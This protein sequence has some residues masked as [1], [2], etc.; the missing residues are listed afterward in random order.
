MGRTD[1]GVAKRLRSL[2]ALQATAV[3]LAV[4]VGFAGAKAVD[5]GE[6]GD[7]AFI[8]GER[9]QQPVDDVMREEGA[10]RVVDQD[11]VGGKIC[12]R[13]E[14]AMHRF[15]PRRAAGN[16]QRAESLRGVRKG[17]GV[18]RV[19]HSHDLADARVTRERS[20]RTADH[21]LARQGPVLFR[22][23]FAR[24]GASPGG[25]DDRSDP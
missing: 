6:G 21:R 11:K 18:I 20:K 3:N 9:I 22:H 25:N 19:D 16:R 23:A 13:F 1:R 12:K 10:G 8:F 4:G 7:G 14:T 15:L 17:C 5:H 24:A 2:D